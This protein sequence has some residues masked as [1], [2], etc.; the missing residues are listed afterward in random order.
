MIVCR[1]LGA[2]DVSLY[3]TGIYD[4]NNLYNLKANFV[5]KYPNINGLVLKQFLLSKLREDLGLQTKF[6]PMKSLNLIK[7]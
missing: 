5:Q 4:Y 3:K 1:L 6:R 2:V 7:S